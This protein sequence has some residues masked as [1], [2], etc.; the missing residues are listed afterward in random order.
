MGGHPANHPPTNHIP[1]G[2]HLD[3]EEQE[4]LDQL[5]HEHP[6]TDR[7]VLIVVAGERE[8]CNGYQYW[9]T[10][11]ATQAAVCF[12]AVDMAARSA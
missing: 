5:K 11:Q 1:H 6:G 8:R 4:Q 10:R 7:S 12:D 9:Q 2:N 3:L